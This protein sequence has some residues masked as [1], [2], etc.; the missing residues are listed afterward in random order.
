VAHK[1]PKRAILLVLVF[2]SLE[3]ILISTRLD[4]CLHCATVHLSLQREALAAEAAAEAAAAVVAE[5]PAAVAVAVAEPEKPVVHS[6]S[7]TTTVHRTP[8][9]IDVKAAASNNT[10]TSSKDI[11]S[12][13]SSTSN[14][15]SSSN[16]SS[17]E[18]KAVPPPRRQPRKHTR[19]TKNSSTGSG[20]SASSSSSSGSG[21]VYLKARTALKRVP[22]VTFNIE[23]ITI[24][25]PTHTSLSAC[26]SRTKYI[27]AQ[28]CFLSFGCTTTVQLTP[29]QCATLCIEH[30]LVL[31][32]TDYASCSLGYTCALCCCSADSCT[33]EESS[34]G[35]L[36]RQ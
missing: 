2:G 19:H 17:S 4:K 12:K 28:L 23:T 25:T 18:V 20:S 6:N 22:E 9:D 32:L 10:N 1:M 29:L 5:P 30:I 16:G 21:N 24:V 15:T 34:T 31:I 33:A 26:A 35:T 27:C 11:C 14:N 3:L 13:N 8:T 7:S 36:P